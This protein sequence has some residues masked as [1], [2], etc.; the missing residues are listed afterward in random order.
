LISCLGLTP[1]ENWEA[2]LRGTCGIRAMDAME[3]T[4]DT[5]RDGG[6]AV[7]LPAD[8]APDL[9]REVRYLK[10]AILDSLYEANAH[11]SLPYPPQRC[12]VMLGTTLHG[13]RAAGR[14]LRSG[15]HG[16]L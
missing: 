15:D 14:F 7:D 9:P 10:R 13:M 2:V 11:E 5:L 6:Q 12:G 1:R 3:L 16:L 4:T 8:F